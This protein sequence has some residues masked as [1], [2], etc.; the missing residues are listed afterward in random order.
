MKENSRLKKIAWWYDKDV[1]ERTAFVYIDGEIVEDV[2]HTDAIKK[3]LD[4]KGI[5]N[6]YDAHYRDEGLW[7][8][9]DA[10]VAF[11]ALYY[12]NKIAFLD[13]YYDWSSEGVTPMQVAEAIKKVHPDFT[14]YMDEET[15]YPLEEAEEHYTKVL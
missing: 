5:D 3:Y 13:P 9:E 2:Y 15:D 12:D 10:K 14:V 4:Q 8:I 7:Y 6:D 11:G 1:D